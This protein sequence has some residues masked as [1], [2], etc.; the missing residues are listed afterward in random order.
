MSEAKLREFAALVARWSAKINLVSKSDIAH[1]WERHVQ[2]SLALVPYMPPDIPFAIDIGS[3]AGF[4]GMVLA[5]ATGVP[6][7]LIESDKR[8]AA[9]LMDAARTLGAPVKVLATRIE[10]AK[11][12]PAMLL[13]ARA[14]AP[15]DKLLSL[16][17]PLLAPGGI[18]L[19]PKGKNHEVEL[20]PASAL[21]HMEVERC[22]NPLNDQACILKVSNLRHVG[23]PG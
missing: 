8:K 2:D 21:W 13:T 16:A 6:F 11:T 19:F 22:K 10:D 3:G 9:F 5:I 20:A 4:P 18:C 23:L 15:L 1:L 17:A 12:P 7:T 14:L